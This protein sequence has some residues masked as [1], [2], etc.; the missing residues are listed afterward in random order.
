L[1]VTDAFW[2]RRLRY[3]VGE[4]IV[5][6]KPIRGFLYRQ[7]GCVRINRNTVD[8]DCIKEAV[9]L[10]RE[11]E[12]MTVFPEGRLYLRAEEIADFKP[13]AALM[14][15]IAGTPVIP[16]YI[17]PKKKAFSR[18]RVMIGAPIDPISICGRFP[19]A[20]GLE[21]LSAE[22]RTIVCALKAE[23]EEKTK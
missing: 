11:G 5:D 3:I 2:R 20:E 17:T 12:A 1:I 22:L 16:V 23:L 19:T 15:V 21:K 7:L 9:K 18:V 8:F 4:N 10:L 14:A 13:G 6:R